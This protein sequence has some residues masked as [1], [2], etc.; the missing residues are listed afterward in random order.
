MKI[1]TDEIY[2]G[3]A[4]IL[5]TNNEFEQKKSIYKYN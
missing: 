3:I 5:Y 2:N 1:R 4:K